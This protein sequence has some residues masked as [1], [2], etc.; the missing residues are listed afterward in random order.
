MATNQPD[1]QAQLTALKAL[2][3]TLQSQL[4]ALQNNPVVAPPIVFARTPALNKGTKLLDYG[5]KTGSIV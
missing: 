4:Q 2:M 3:A 1:E 5:V